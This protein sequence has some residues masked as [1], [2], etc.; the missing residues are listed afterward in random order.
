M[1]T[2]RRVLGV[3]GTSLEL[4]ALGLR[5]HP[6]DSPGA[7]AHHGRGQD[8][9]A[10]P[11]SPGVAAPRPAVLGPQHRAL[12]VPM[13]GSWRENHGWN[14]HGWHRWQSLWVPALPS[15]QPSKAARALGES[16]FTERQAGREPRG[17]R[18]L[19]REPTCCCGLGPRPPAAW[20]GVWD[21]VGQTRGRLCPG[22]TLH[23]LAARGSHPF[24]AHVFQSEGAGMYLWPFLHLTDSRET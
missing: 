10:A 19:C 9:A 17:D 7:S 13:V 24:S 5:S 18:G 16:V 6:Q 14:V 12:L 15:V 20:K 2:P 11:L 22:P 21:E 4:L 8:F 1:D 3:E 23:Q